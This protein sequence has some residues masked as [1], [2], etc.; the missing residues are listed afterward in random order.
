[1]A[2]AED[3]VRVTRGQTTTYV[4]KTGARRQFCPGCGTGLFYTNAEM[5]PGII[6]IQSATLDTAADEVPGA[7][8]QVAERLPWIDDLTALHRFE[9]YPGQ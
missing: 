9:R 8:I 6:D 3:Q 4:G 1:M 7:Q 2:I 5:L